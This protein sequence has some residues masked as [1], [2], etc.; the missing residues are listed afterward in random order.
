MVLSLVLGGPDI[1]SELR[2]L[3]NSKHESKIIGEDILSELEEVFSNSFSWESNK[4]PINIFIDNMKAIQRTS[5]VYFLSQKLFPFISSTAAEEL[6]QYTCKGSYMYGVK[7]RWELRRKNTEI[8]PRKK[9]QREGEKGE[10]QG[11][12]GNT[13]LVIF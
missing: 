9:Y 10:C 13:Y 3:L 11:L 2:K 6:F 1:P 4:T 5:V 7:I 12:D 8:V